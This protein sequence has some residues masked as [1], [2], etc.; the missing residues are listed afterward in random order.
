MFVKEYPDRKKKEKKVPAIPPITT[1]R[2]SAVGQEDLKPYKISEKRH[3]F[4]TNQKLL[5]FTTFQRLY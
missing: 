2:R 4:L 3:I 5:L 1:N